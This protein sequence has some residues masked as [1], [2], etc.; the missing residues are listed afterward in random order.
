MINSARMIFCRFC[1]A[2]KAHRYGRD[3][4]RRQRYRCPS[5]GRIFTGRT[6]TVKSWSRFSERQWEIAARLFSL[7]QGISGTDLARFLDVHP[8]TGQKAN[9]IL[10]SLTGD[11]HPT[12]L[13]GASEWDESCPSGQW[14]LGGVSRTVQ[15]CLLQIIPNRTERTLVPAIEAATDGESLV[16]TD[17]WGGYLRLLNH[18]TVNHSKGFINRDA[19]FVHTNSVEGIWGH[20]KPLAAHVYRGFPR[21]T[22]QMYLSEVM[23]R[24][25][26]RCHKTRFSVLS[27]LLSRKTNSF[28][29]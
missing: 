8:H 13:C 2:S 9:R 23:F 5:C 18:W 29:V 16:F 15:Q 25:N 10:R 11:L 21:S 4:S 19:R 14:V 27:A 20:L 22:L 7:R 6:N 1:G 24:Y 17:E 3:R 26:I 12:R 28:L